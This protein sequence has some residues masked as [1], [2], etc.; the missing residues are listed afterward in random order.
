MKPEFEI[1]TGLPSI[2]PLPVWVPAESRRSG[3]EGFVVRFSTES[4]GDWI[5]NFRLGG[6]GFHG[7][8]QH[9]SGH[10]WLVVAGGDPYVVDKSTKSARSLE[11]C[12]P[13]S[14]IWPIEDSVDLI[15]EVQGLAFLRLGHE[16]VKWHSRRISWDGFQDVAVGGDTVTGKAW[17]PITDNPLHPFS[18]DIQT[19]RTVGG[20]PDVPDSAWERLAVSPPESS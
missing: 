15:L 11:D 3:R 10:E 16:G 4:E 17:S 18:L 12:L 20:A 6:V 2:G 5:A 9:P 14:R 8:T 1:L 19:G 13:I 7:V